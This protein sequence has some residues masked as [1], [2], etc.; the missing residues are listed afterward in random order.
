PMTAAGFLAARALAREGVPV[1]Y[2]LGFSARQNYL[3]ARFSRT[4]YVNV[5]MGRLNAVVIDNQLGDGEYVGEK[6]TMASQQGLRQLAHGGR[7]VPRQIGASMRTAAQLYDLAGLDVFTMPTH[8]ARDFRQEMETAPRELT[9][10]V[11]REF[12]VTL[13]PGVDPRAVGIN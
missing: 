10:Q 7:P 4:A 2:T 13:N 1:N 3:A 11:E 8:V 5:F 6:A 9:S 12:T